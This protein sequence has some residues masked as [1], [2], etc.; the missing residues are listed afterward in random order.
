MINGAQT[1]AAS[2]KFI[3]DNSTADVSK[4]RVSL[5]LINADLDGQ[6][7]KFV[8]RE[9]IIRIRCSCQIFALDDEQERLR[10]DIAHL[11]IRYAYKAKDQIQPMRQIKSE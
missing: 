4:A 2:A 6:F 9:Q 11:G 10:R 3:A 5:T 1:I 8:T 7:G